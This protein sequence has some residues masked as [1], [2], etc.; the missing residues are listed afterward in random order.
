MVDTLAE[1]ADRTSVFIIGTAWLSI[2]WD[3][4]SPPSSAW[5]VTLVIL[6]PEIVTVTVTEPYRCCT[7]VP[8]NVPSLNVVLPFEVVVVPVFVDEVVVP[9]FVLPVVVVFATVAPLA[10]PAAHPAP[11]TPAEAMT[12][13]NFA[14]VLTRRTF[15]CG[16][17][18]S[19]YRRPGHR[20]S[21]GRWRS[22]GHIRTGRCRPRTAPGRR[23]GYR[24]VMR[25]SSRSRRGGSRYA[26]RPR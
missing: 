11:R 22:A 25:A 1:L 4:R 26:T 21:P 12:A 14:R 6:P 9:V 17:N 19:G 8:V 10:V 16:W 20:R 13:A 15:R 2:D 5:A 23:A 24:G 7:V 18:R 3:L